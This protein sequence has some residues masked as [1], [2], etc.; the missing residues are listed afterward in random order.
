MQNHRL[1]VF[2]KKF[3]PTAFAH[4]AVRGRGIGGKPV[5]RTKKQAPKRLW[6]SLGGAEYQNS[7]VNSQYRLPDSRIAAGK[8][9]TQAIARLR[10][11]RICKPEP[12]AVML[13]ATPD[14]NT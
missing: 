2:A 8:V 14:D 10:R 12:L 11:V 6:V 1:T 3:C 5:L 9:S 7:W 4:S 13:P